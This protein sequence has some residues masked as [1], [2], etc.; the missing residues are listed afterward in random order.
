MGEEEFRLDV[1]APQYVSW[2]THP[3]RD[4]E[5][6]EWRARYF[7]GGTGTSAGFDC[8]ALERL[9]ARDRVSHVVVG[10]DGPGHGAARACATLAPEFEGERATVFA[11]RPRR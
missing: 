5:V 10:R 8:A 3:Y 11:V 2:K 7:G 6:L 9:L 1:L 4:V